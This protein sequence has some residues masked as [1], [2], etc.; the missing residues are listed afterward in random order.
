M[1]EIF[2][3]LGLCVAGLVAM[4]VLGKMAEGKDDSSE[5]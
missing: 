4:I 3:V 1:F 2:M 5:G